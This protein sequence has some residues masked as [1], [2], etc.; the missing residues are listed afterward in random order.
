MAA[1]STLMSKEP[2]LE[3][4]AEV[5]V[6]TLSSDEVALL[7]MASLRV[8]SALAAVCSAVSL[9]LMSVNFFDI[10]VLADFFDSRRVIGCL[11]MDNIDLIS[12][13]ESIPVA[14]PL[15]VVVA[16]MRSPGQ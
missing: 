15:N 8:S 3:P 4:P 11:A 14:K 2:R 9:V 1:E 7:T 12:A 10:A 16:A 5:T 13:P 6:K